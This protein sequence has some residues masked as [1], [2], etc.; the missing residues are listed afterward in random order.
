MTMS[1]EVD[2]ALPRI[3]DLIQRESSLPAAIAR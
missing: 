2:Q 1:P 3:I